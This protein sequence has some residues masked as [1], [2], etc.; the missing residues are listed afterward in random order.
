MKKLLAYLLRPLT[1]VQRLRGP[2]PTPKEFVRERPF[3]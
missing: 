3:L 1:L 2:R